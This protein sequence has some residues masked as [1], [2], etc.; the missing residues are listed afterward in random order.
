MG[1]AETRL[2]RGVRLDCAKHAPWAWRGTR[3]CPGRMGKCLRERVASAPLCPS[4]WHLSCREGPQWGFSIL[5]AAGWHP[6]VSCPQS[7]PTST[8]SE[9]LQLA[10]RVSPSCFSVWS[11]LLCLRPTF[12]KMLVGNRGC[13]LTPGWKRS[14]L[15][16]SCFVSL[17]SAQ[18]SG[19]GARRTDA[20]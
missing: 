18:A 17:S 1:V 3:P 2:G 19:R 8:L 10:S 9:L 4:R 11:S 12:L 15:Q 14:P 13:S 16:F 5:L 6:Q 7:W 20:A